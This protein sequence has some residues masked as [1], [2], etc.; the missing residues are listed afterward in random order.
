MLFY[1][2]EDQQG[3]VKRTHAP[4]ALRAVITKARKYVK[5]VRLKRL[6]H[7]LHTIACF[8]IISKVPGSRLEAR[9]GP[10][11]IVVCSDTLE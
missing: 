8:G 11:C 3:S 6:D 7:F 4:W 5:V 1:F 2:V 10:M 9:I